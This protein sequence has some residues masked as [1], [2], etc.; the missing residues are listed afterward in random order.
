MQSGG[1]AAM[2]ELEMP[3]ISPRMLV[4]DDDEALLKLMSA[5][6]GER[7]SRC[8]LATSLQ[9]ARNLMETTRYD[10]LFLDLKLPDGWGTSL[11]EERLNFDPS[12]VAVIVSAEQALDTVIQVIRQG[13]Y[14]FIT[15]PFRLELF[16][17]RLAR[18]L[19][20]WRSR[21]RYQYYQTHLEGLVKTMM[22]KLSQATRQIEGTYDATVAAL[23]AALDLRDPETEEHCRR[24]A[25]NSLRLG[26]ALRLGQ[27]ELRTL[28]WSAYLHDIG[29]IGIPEHVLFKSSGLTAME[30]E[31]VK[32]HPV[33]GFNMLSS[34][35]F[36]KE[37][38]EVV[39][40]HHEKYDGSGYPHGLKG[41]DIPLPARIFAVVDAMD[42]M[43]NDRPYRRALPFSA[44]LEELELQSGKHFDPDIA[45]EV[46]QIPEDAWRVEAGA[47]KPIPERI[48]DAPASRK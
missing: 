19:E 21:R 31:Q 5:I 11:L 37:A 14:D 29:K 13:A 36:L 45:R 44:F 22:D 48:V 42:A 38:A 24:V 47:E 2:T 1:E 20:E 10:I 23:G 8:D 35:S 15:K 32:M 16:Q 33:L 3:D 34:I 25:E 4:V 30:M 40:Y 7:A 17:E 41:A 27:A 18:V 9:D 6:I 26:K 43:I 28:R 46:L 39:L 12:T